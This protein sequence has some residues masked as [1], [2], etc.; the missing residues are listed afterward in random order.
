[1]EIFTN[2]CAFSSDSPEMVIAQAEMT[3]AEAE[4]TKA[5]AEVTKSKAEKAKVNVCK[6]CFSAFH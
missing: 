4:V 3:K 1:L 2:P 6:Y 5:E